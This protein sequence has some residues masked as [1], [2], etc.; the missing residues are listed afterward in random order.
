[1]LVWI[2]G[3]IECMCG[4][5]VVEVKG[6]RVRYY[7][8]QQAMLLARRYD[9]NNDRQTLD[10]TGLTGQDMTEWQTGQA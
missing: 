4:A 5:E 10:W 3:K 7:Y 6:S 1:M 8:Q 9:G 2:V